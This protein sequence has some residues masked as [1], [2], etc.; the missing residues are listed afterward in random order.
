MA[1]VKIKEIDSLF[2]LRHAQRSDKVATTTS[3]IDFVAS[4]SHHNIHSNPITYTI[5]DTYNPPLATFQSTNNKSN[6]GYLQSMNLGHQILNYIEQ[7]IEEETVVLKFHT[8]PYLRCIETIRYILDFL[9]K[10]YQYEY[11]N[12][13]TKTIRCIITIDQVLSEWLSTDLDIDLYPPHDNGASLLGAAIQYL[14]SNLPFH[15]NN[16]IEIQ[17]DYN[18]S[19][20]H[21]NPGVFSESFVQQYSRLNNGL[22]SIVKNEHESLSQE[23]NT[24]DIVL[25]MTHGA[26]V[27]SIVSKLLGKS[28][29]LEIPLASLSIAKPLMED[30]KHY[31]WQL[32][33]TDIETRLPHFHQVDLYSKMDPF[34]DYQTTFNHN[35]NHNQLNFQKLI[36]ASKTENFNRIRSQSLLTPRR[37][38]KLSRKKGD[39]DDDEDDEDVDDDDSSDEGITFTTRRRR[40]TTSAS[41][42]NVDNQ[43]RF[44]SSSLFGPILKNPFFS[45]D[46]LSDYND[47]SK[48]QISKDTN[49]FENRKKSLMKQKI[50][51]DSINP[52]Q[53]DPNSNSYQNIDE[54]DGILGKPIYRTR[55]T[56]EN[57]ISSEI[58]NELVPDLGGSLSSNNSSSHSLT[59]INDDDD[60]ELSVFPGTLSKLSSSSKEQD[61]SSPTPPPTHFDT[62]MDPTLHEPST[63]STMQYHN[64]QDF[65]STSTLQVNNT[66]SEQSTINNNNNNSNKKS[67]IFDKSLIEKTLNEI[68]I[69]EPQDH[70]KE[71]DND[72]LLFHNKN[73]SISKPKTPEPDNKF[74]IN[75]YGKKDR[76]R[77][78]LYGD[79]NES[80]DGSNGW[81]LGSNKY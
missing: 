47:Q 9:V 13:N 19:Y 11:G 67:S 64:D 16:Q 51:I 28:L 36:P 2:I 45:D 3:S 40:V 6:N 15:R 69:Q 20:K 32:L 57:S 22:I 18:N 34:Q 12:D 42:S 4:N 5:S 60:Q 17:L 52:K 10:S 81:F 53:K 50:D 44:R 70:Q 33:K 31:Y 56:K 21:G 24:K 41:S 75:L 30:S 61:S 38:S 26:C 14:N 23:P 8:S 62:P 63:S 39:D 59:D 58:S 27:R 68:Q 43:R 49:S 66:I 35:S 55:S 78:N 29:H 76:L 1:K 48:N 46:S 37:N 7:N 72:W 73:K 25:L 65:S 71:L 74:K 79:D 77:L 54:D 80:D